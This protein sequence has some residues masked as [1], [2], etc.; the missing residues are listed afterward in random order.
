MTRSPART[1]IAIWAAML[2]LPVPMPA[3]GEPISPA[4][5][6]VAERQ[7]GS[8]EPAHNMALGGQAYAAGRYDRARDR[9]EA[10]AAAYAA[11]G[12]R[13]GQLQTANFLALAYQQLGQWETAREAV[14]R[15]QQLLDESVPPALQAQTHNSEASL[16]L[17]T[18]D[19]TT[20]IAAWE[21]AEARYAQAGDRAGVLGSQLNC[22]RALQQMGNLRRAETLLLEASDRLAAEFPDS[23]LLLRGWQS[24]GN[25]R[26]ARGDFQAAR[27]DLEAA[28]NLA[29]QL[30]ANREASA[31]HLT[32][33]N[34][35]R[36]TGAAEASPDRLAAAS[37][38]ADSPQAQ[39]T[40]AIA[41]LQERIA[42]ANWGELPT[43]AEGA[44]EALA[45]LSPG[46]ARL[47]ATIAI[48]ANL[49][50]A[51]AAATATLEPQLAAQLDRAVAATATLGDR[52]RLARIQLLQARWQARSGRPA[53]ARSGLEA[54]LQAAQA[55]SAPE[56]IAPA[57]W[58]LGRLATAE[59]DRTVAIAAYEEAIAALQAL[60]GDL[61]ATSRD[62]QFSFRQ[63]I[64]PVYR[65][66][67]SLLLTEAPSQNELQQARATIEALRL[68]ELDNFFREACLD[69]QS[70]A[71]ESL[72][73][74][75]AVIYPIL[76][77]ERMAVIVSRA[78]E[79]LE[80]YTLPLPRAEVEAAAD[81]LLST[82]HPAAD[83]EDRLR[84]SQIFYDWLV[85][86]AEMQGWLEGIETLV[87]VLDGNLRQLPVAALFDG[88]RYLIER[89]GVALSPGLQLLQPRRSDRRP[90]RTSLIAGLSEARGGFTALPGVATELD[91]LEAALPAARLMNDDFTKERLERA[92]VRRPIEI[93]HLATHG[94][95]GSRPEDT[96]L[97]AWDGPI[98]L[99][100]IDAL[101][102]ARN[103][104]RDDIG[105]DLLVLS[106]CETAAGDEMAILGLA[107]F[108]VSS[109]ARSTVA[110]LWQVNDRSTA[111]L[112]GHFYDRLGEPTTAKAEALRRA[113][114]QLLKDV[115]YNHP[116]FWAPFV[117]IG[118]WR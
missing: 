34:L 84:R 69:A 118:H 41:Y 2:A 103:A 52:R 70:V 115:Q 112:M 104:A 106:A 102:L 107:G 73:P 9:W 38:L 30:G 61:A 43:T 20:A 98:D 51:P 110:T 1:A 77:P 33:A 66:L 46:P 79:P 28:L 49:L 5:I 97:Q 81:V 111:R 117:L 114:M 65:E 15:G 6:A 31:L 16:A 24:L 8:D 21:R 10:A 100:A 54:A 45:G 64:E 59:G 57:A 101:L 74:K 90:R 63:T 88:D 14:A 80:Y 44:W 37:A 83:N 11:S 18:G 40:V 7:A 96:F 48:A 42:R 116:F 108:A 50:R 67:V 89:Y 113:Q 92:V 53:A 105:L 99:R 75:A 26:L 27:A 17:A 87:F 78:G 56:I 3:V 22:A 13:L 109:G 95:F 23:P 62:T 71:I 39:T 4:A 35:D 93:L 94:Q 91:R 85:R 58:E 60:R 55:L 29:L 68:A 82:F 32:L 72:D 12:D 76:L 25:V 19:T 47:D 36:K 86:P